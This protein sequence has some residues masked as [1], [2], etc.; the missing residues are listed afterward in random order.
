[1][2]LREVA[3]PAVLGSRPDLF[4]DNLIQVQRGNGRRFNPQLLKIPSRAMQGI[5]VRRTFVSTRTAAGKSATFLGTN[6]NYIAS[7]DLHAL[8]G[9]RMYT[10]FVAWE[11]LPISIKKPCL[12]VRFHQGRFLT[13]QPH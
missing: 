5:K 4:T 10:I 1:M 6:V 8:C 3:Y 7:Q 12:P 2:K 13:P 11:L 9:L